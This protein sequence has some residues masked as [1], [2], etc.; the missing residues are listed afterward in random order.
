VGRENVDQN[1]LAELVKHL[2]LSGAD[3]VKVGLGPG[4]LTTEVLVER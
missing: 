1:V 2:D 4:R 3:V